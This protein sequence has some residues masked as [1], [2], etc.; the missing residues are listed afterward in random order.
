MATITI[1]DHVESVTD[2][3]PVFDRSAA[4]IT[5]ADLVCEL[6]KMHHVDVICKCISITTVRFLLASDMVI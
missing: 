4:G 1:E 6:L 2:G 3:M 5:G